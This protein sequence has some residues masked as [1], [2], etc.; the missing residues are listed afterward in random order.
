MCTTTTAWQYTHSSEQA[1]AGVT[2]SRA[3][4]EWP[5]GP[6]GRIVMHLHDVIVGLWHASEKAREPIEYLYDLRSVDTLKCDLD[7]TRMWATD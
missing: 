7:E 1:N 2:R 3:A 5:G 4:G 6:A